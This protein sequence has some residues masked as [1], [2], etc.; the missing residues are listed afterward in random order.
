[1]QVQGAAGKG[2]GQSALRAPRGRTARSGGQPG[3]RPKR[4]YHNVLNVMSAASCMA[5]TSP[6][7]HYRTMHTRSSQQH[8]AAREEQ[9]KR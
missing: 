8:S 7:R 4:A 1:M 3:C 2:A 9:E 5:I 6:Q